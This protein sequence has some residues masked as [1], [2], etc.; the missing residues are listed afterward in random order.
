[1]PIMFPYQIFILIL[2]VMIIGYLMFIEKVF[3]KKVAC[4]VMMMNLFPFTS[5][6]YKLLYIFIPLFL[7]INY[8]K[9]EKYDLVFIILFSL[10]L[11]PKDYLYFNNWPLATFNVVINPIIMTLILI[12]IIWSGIKTKL[13]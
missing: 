12:I 1:L 5:T 9:K 13:K 6:D 2:S 7:F 8:P 4:L 3:W 11:I 10:L